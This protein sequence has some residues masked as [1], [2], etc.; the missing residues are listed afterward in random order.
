MAVFPSLFSEEH[1]RMRRCCSGLTRRSQH[2]VLYSMCTE[3]LVLP[4]RAHVGVFIGSQ[5]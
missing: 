3:I 1:S 5:F 2:D 4:H